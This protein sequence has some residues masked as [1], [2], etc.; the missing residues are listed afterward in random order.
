ME[1]NIQQFWVALKELPPEFLNEEVAT[2]IGRTIGCVF[3]LD[4]EDAFYYAKQPH[5][6]C[7]E[8][9]TMNHDEE[10]CKDRANYVRDTE[11]KL[12]NKFRSN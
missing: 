11:N 8:C 4:H 6:L 9:F 5:Q 1:F 10:K 3:E 12:F 2:E 7:P